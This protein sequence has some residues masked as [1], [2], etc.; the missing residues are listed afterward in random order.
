[1]GIVVADEIHLTL[2]YRVAAAWDIITN[3]TAW[4]AYGR[5]TPWD[6]EDN[7]PAEDST[8]TSME[9]VQGFRLI[10]PANKGCVYPSDANDYDFT[11]HGVYWKK[12]TSF[13]DALENGARWA[14]FELNL[15]VGDGLPVVTFRQ[16]GLF[17][18]LVP[19][20]GYEGYAAL[21]PAQTDSTGTFYYYANHT[22]WVRAINQSDTIVF[23]IEY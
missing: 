1:M 3:Y 4:G 18:D 2:G 23:V 6:D 12:A 9:E 10:V 21:L 16:I 14:L 15:L 13:E 17:L 19:A 20:S 7:P 5:T 22:K 11:Y 8:A